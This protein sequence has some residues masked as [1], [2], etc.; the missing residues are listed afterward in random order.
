VYAGG[1]FKK[2]DVLRYEAKNKFWVNIG[3][4]SYVELYLDGKKVPS[5]SERTVVFQ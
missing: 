1:E 5:F 4:P 2:G 3:R